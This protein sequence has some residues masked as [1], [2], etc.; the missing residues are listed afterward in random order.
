MRKPF[1]EAGL[2]IPALFLC[3]LAANAQPQTFPEIVPLPDGFR[4]EG[5]ALGYGHTIFAGSLS[6]G[7]I[8][9]ADLRTGAGDLVV[10]PQVG[11]IAVGLAFDRRSNMIFVAGGTA[12]EAYVYDAQT[13]ASVAEYALDSSGEAFINDVVVSRDAAYF[14]NSFKPELY[15]VPL[16]PRDRLPDPGESEVIPLGGDFVQVPGFNSN[17]IDSTAD[18][19]WLI[20]VNSSLG[21]LYRVA[22][23]TGDAT[24]I[25]LGGAD[26]VNGDGVVLEGRT[27]YVV[28]N[29]LNQ[30]AVIELAPDLASGDVVWLITSPEF[31]VPTTAAGFGDALYAVNARF[32]TPPEPTTEY[33]IV[34]VLK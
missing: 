29:R 20:V 19:K 11:R 26:V 22:P 32:G 14:T 2:L 16:G 25:D 3:V 27:L 10:P 9:K 17:G 1:F 31:D 34:R 18:G 30:I 12:G 21:T 8:Y 7:S 13:G 5:V 33:G 24:L 6:E 23:S 15:K 28:Q 4:P